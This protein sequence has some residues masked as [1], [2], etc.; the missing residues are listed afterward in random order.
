MPT[1]S[2]G[3]SS[4]AIGRPPRRD[5]SAAPAHGRAVGDDDLAD[6]GTRERDRHLL[7]DVAGAED[8]DPPPFERTQP[9]RGHRDRGRRDRHRV[10]RDAGLGAGPLADLD[11]LAEGAGQELADR[12][13]TLGD[14][15][16]LAD[17]AEDLA[18]ADDHRVESGGHAEQVRD[19][20]VLVVRVEEVGELVGVHARLVGEEVADVVDAGWN[21]VVRA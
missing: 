2:S 21:I 6:A 1:S 20:R 8:E 3:I 17:L 14:L 13:L 18:L 12:A 19:R 9:F 10:A 11:G 16:R 5:A 7:A 15:P 4:S